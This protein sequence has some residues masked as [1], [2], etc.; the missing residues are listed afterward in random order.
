MAK[1]K[2]P[3]RPRAAS[4]SPQP[5]SPP[6]ILEIVEKVAT[7]TGSSSEHPAQATR[8]VGAVLASPHQSFTATVECSSTNG[9]T[10]KD[11]D[12]LKSGSSLVPD[13]IDGQIPTDCVFTPVVQQAPTWCEVVNPTNKRM[14]RKGEV[15][16]LESGELCVTIPNEVIKRN[17]HKWDKF[18]LAQFH[19]TAPSPGALHAIANGIWSN[20]LRDITISKL[21]ERAFLICIPCSITR[22]RVLAQ[23]MW[24]IENQSM[25]VGKWEP[26]LNPEIPKLTSAPVWVDFRGVPHQF[27][28]EEALEHVAGMVGD[29][30]RVHPSTLNMTNLEV[31]RVLTIIN[32]SIPLPEFVNV[33]FQS[34]E[35]KR[36]EVSS[37]WLPPT[38]ENCK[39]V[40]HSIRRCPTAPIL[41]TSCNSTVHSTDLC[42]RAKKVVKEAERLPIP[43]LKPKKSKQKKISKAVAP[44][45]I[46]QTPLE[47]QLPHPSKKIP[48]K[49]SL[50]A[51]GKAVEDLSSDSEPS[52]S[53]EDCSTGYR[54]EAGNIQSDDEDN[55]QVDDEFLAVV[56]KRQAKLTKQKKKKG[57]K[58]GKGPKST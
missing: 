36:V 53:S 55:P 43:E 49:F 11:L 16:V 18:I 29:P 50:K 3:P 25:F 40:G 22:Q 19:G 26:G 37:P 41:C 17:Q 42:P 47:P 48:A 51:K 45:G 31:A 8:E 5:R 9:S 15:T 34:G 24:H 33:R 13:S 23:G 27:F 38:C 54:S 58:R 44:K 2:K 56:S 46:E 32:P 1:S 57:Q 14:T 4:V 6:R 30:V 12:A 28:S 20:K 7:S 35:M 39:E 52:S 21:S 10:S